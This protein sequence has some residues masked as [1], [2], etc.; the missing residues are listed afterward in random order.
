MEVKYCLSPQVCF[1]C[2][3]LLAK[4]LRYIFLLHL[5]WAQLKNRISTSA[6]L[7]NIP[8]LESANIRCLPHL[9]EI[10]NALP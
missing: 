9:T 1:R 5:L 3:N 8:R 7:R 6:V 10:V 4:T 2:I